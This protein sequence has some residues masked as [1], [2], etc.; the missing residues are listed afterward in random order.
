MT[1]GHNGLSYG[2]D[3]AYHVPQNTFLVAKGPYMMVMA[4]LHSRCG[5][6]IFAL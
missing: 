4:T 3:R 5:H 6:Y 2:A 1:V